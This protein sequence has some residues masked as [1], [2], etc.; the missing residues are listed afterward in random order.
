LFDRLG[1]FNEAHR[2]VNNDLDYCLRV[3]RD[4][5][6]IIF[7]PYAKLIHHEQASRTTIGD[8]YDLGHFE[9]E[10]LALFLHGD[11]YFN[12]NLS[13]DED[14]FVA[15]RETTRYIYPGNPVLPDRPFAK[16][17]VVKL[18]HIG[19]CILALPAIHR[20]KALFPQAK[21][22]VLAAPGTKTIWAGE[23]WVEEVI[24]FDFFHAQSGAGRK[25]VSTD[26]YERL[27]ARL[28]PYRFD[29][30]IDLR[31]HPDTRPILRD[32]GARFTAGFD[33]QNQFPWLDFALEW[34]GNPPLV[35]KRGHVSDDLMN[36]VALVANASA[37]APARESSQGAMPKK[38]AAVAKAMFRRRVIAI[39][40]GA[41]T[42]MRQWPP[43]YFAELIDL[44][45]EEEDVHIALIGTEAE[46]A[47]VKVLTKRVRR[48][49]SVWDFVGKIG[50]AELP[51]LLTRCALFIGNNSGPKHLAASLGVPTIG[52]SSGVVDAHEWG[53]V[54]PAAIAVTR[55]MDCAPCYLIRPED[56][57]RGLACLKGLRPGEI[58]R[59]SKRLLA[60]HAPV[61][62][63]ASSASKPASP[64]RASSVS[65]A[66]TPAAA[67][68]RKQ[69][70]AS[71]LSSG[72][73]RPTS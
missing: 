72:S 26:Q 65:A 38:V 15:E 60:L 66:P 16:I 20:L 21:S 23:T 54:G 4:G 69:A 58:H 62:D 41:G 6:K 56:C 8:E 36:L 29:L 33:Y 39:H 61:L 17:L 10:W 2:V 42:V 25:N 50:L 27:R 11:P 48:G 3:W 43:E 53:P 1:G 45:I 7:T 31:K 70:K 30:A 49:A 28:A 44:L 40:P 71:S 13:N 59:V 9:R 46:R 52:I 12:P 32:T 67:A 68:R 73:P 18:D 22:Y 63:Q 57:L 14:H 51:G 37:P 64:R 24:E 55:E 34:E 35:R 5:L 19:D 47:I